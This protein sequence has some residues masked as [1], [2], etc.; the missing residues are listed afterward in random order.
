MA[1]GGICVHREVTKG[2]IRGVGNKNAS[3]S[4]AVAAYV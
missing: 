2:Q 4:G 1:I 3:S